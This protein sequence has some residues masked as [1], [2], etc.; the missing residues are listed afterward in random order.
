MA[1]T[2]SL[3]QKNKLD[4]FYTKKNTA[5]FCISQLNMEDYDIIIEPSAGSGSFS[6]QIDNCIAYDIAPE[7]ANIIKQDYLALEINENLLNKKVLV[8]GNPPF[9]VQNNLAIN[10]FNH[11]AKFADTIAFILPRSFRKQS[12]QNRLSLDFSLVLDIDLP[13]DSFQLDGIDYNVPAVFQVWNKI[14]RKK[15]KLIYEVN[16]IE[17][18][19]AEDADFRIQRVGGNAGKAFYTTGSKQSNYFIRNTTGIDNDTLISLINAEECGERN[20]TVG[21]RSISK[22]ELLE[23]IKK[24][25][26]NN[27]K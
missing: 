6:S 14:P 9:G 3:G 17:F 11:S 5:L 24:I 2:K 13:E 25:L 15:E 1:T 27:Y 8:I 23:K 22:P 26:E 18:V 12:I 19:S 20:N 21:P 16:G 4:K 10:F 7:G